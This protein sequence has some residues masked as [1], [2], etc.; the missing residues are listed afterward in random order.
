MV[1]VVEGEV[2]EVRRR[3]GL[4]WVEVMVG[5]GGVGWEVE[6]EEEEWCGGV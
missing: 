1:E 6:G 4:W 2:G 5:C 3:E